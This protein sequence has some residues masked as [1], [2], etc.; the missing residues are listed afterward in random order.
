MSSTIL[1]FQRPVSSG[2]VLDTA[3]RLFKVSLVRCLPLSLA[4]VVMGQLPTAYALASGRRPS[5]SL[6][7]DPVDLVLVV[8]AGL[9][10]LL[11]WGAILLR[12]HAIAHGRASTLVAD[13][14]RVLWLL[15]PSIAM[16]LLSVLLIALG[17]VLLVVPGLYLAVALLFAYPAMLIDDQPVI[18]ALRASL[19]LVRGNWWRTSLVLTVAL[20]A[21]IVFFAVGSVAGLVVSRLVG[22]GDVG[23]DV[24][25]TS[26]ITSL[27]GALFTPFMV[28]LSLAQYDDLKL[29]R[30]GVDLASRIDALPGR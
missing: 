24:L 23:T 4:A 28:A 14:R 26:V 1:P 22:G 10:N 7:T 3:F 16:A 15:V 20:F 19:R 29:R 9:A 18:G 11:L 2:E 30:D 6:E 8:V 21:V 25:V 12:Q 13:L 27:I 17:L 5:V